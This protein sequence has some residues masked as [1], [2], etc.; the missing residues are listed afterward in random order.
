MSSEL[1]NYFGE[2][3]IVKTS[4]GILLYVQRKGVEDIIQDT[5][6]MIEILTGINLIRMRNA[7]YNMTLD[8]VED[9]YVR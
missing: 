3:V 6:F 9:A 4:Y 2:R 8:V 7:F 1:I 5:A